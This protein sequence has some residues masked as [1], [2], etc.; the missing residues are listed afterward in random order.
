[1]PQTNSHSPS[2]KARAA[3]RS[4]HTSS[5]MPTAAPSVSAEAVAGRAYEKFVARGCSHGCDREDWLAAE[6]ELVA[7]AGNG[8]H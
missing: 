1:M 2:T 4:A 8:S 3:E 6:Q 7:E 5:V